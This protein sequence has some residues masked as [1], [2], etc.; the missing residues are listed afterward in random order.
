MDES[1]K[2]AKKSSRHAYLLEFAVIVV[3]A[4]L[5]AYAGAA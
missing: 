3:L 5:A 2:A 4:A 1:F